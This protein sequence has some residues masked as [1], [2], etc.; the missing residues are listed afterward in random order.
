MI[1]IPDVSGLV[2]TTIFDT[3]NKGADN[4]IPDLSTLVKK[5]DYK[6]KIEG[7]YFTT[8]VYKKVSSEILNAKMKPNSDIYNLVKNFDLN[9]KA[10]VKS[11]QDKIVKLQA[12]N[13]SY[14]HD[15]NFFSNDNFQNMLFINQQLKDKGTVYAIG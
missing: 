12:F 2:T 6:A 15:K 7:K 14:F 10:E 9:T 13:P 4:K 8:F 1:K 11:E 5:T 3:K